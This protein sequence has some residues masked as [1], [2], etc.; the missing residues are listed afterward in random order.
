[1]SKLIAFTFFLFRL[2][3]NLC[4]SY[5]ARPNEFKLVE[6]NGRAHTGQDLAKRAHVNKVPTICQKGDQI[7]NEN[8]LNKSSN[9][10]IGS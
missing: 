2:V 10:R 1:M 3:V 5:S 4:R 7:F 9:F 8:P 6:I